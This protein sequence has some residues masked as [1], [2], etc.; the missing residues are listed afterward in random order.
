MKLANSLYSTISILSYQWEL[1]WTKKN[2][3]GGKKEERKEI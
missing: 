3:N 2:K 1:Q